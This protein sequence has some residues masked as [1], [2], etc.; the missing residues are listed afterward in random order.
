MSDEVIVSNSIASACF[1]FKGGMLPLTVLQILDSSLRG[2]LPQL[3]AKIQQAPNFFRHAPVVIDLQKIK[4]ESHPINFVSLLKILKDQGLIP[5]GVRNGNQG[6]LDAAVN[7]GLAIFPENKSE[8]KIEA[9]HSITAL[10]ETGTT[11]LITQPVRTGQQFSNPEGDLIVL[12]TVSCGA[13]LLASGNIHVYGALRCR[14]L[15]GI[16]G[17]TEA[18]IFCQSLEAELVS[19]AG[20]FQVSEDLSKN[21]NWKQ[22]AMIQLQYDQLSIEKL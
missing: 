13:E 15:A 21:S 9:P 18:R 17:N 16:N 14:A 19:I 7:A 10:H 12:S 2:F 20:Q 22:P 5:I 4:Q 6:Q 1:Q 11:R 3:I 8:N